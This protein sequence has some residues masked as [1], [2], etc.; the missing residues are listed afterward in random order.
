MSRWRWRWRHVRAVELN[1]SDQ[2]TQYREKGTLLDNITQLLLREV[3]FQG[4]HIHASMQRLMGRIGAVVGSG[5]R[6]VT[7]LHV[8]PILS[9]HSNGKYKTMKEITMHD[10]IY[11]GHIL[12]QR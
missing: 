12:K 11:T 6:R 2:L 8:L 3:R 10:K 1:R 9:D 4:F 7:A 5:R